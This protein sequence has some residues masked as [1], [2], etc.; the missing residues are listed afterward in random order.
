MVR[1]GRG[2]S[3]YEL[4]VCKADGERDKRTHLE[5]RV[6]RADI[7]L[8]LASAAVEVEG[9]SEGDGGV[10]GDVLQDGASQEREESEER[11]TSTNLLITDV[12][13]VELHSLVPALVVRV[14]GELGRDSLAARQRERSAPISTGKVGAKRPENA[15][16]LFPGSDELNG[17]DGLRVLDLQGECG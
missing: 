14:V 7:L 17:G 11:K 10:H 4:A 13:L 12:D 1:C 2:G 15:P 5:S 6:R 8:D 16:G 9:G 3:E